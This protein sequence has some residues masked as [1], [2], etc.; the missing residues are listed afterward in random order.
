MENYLKFLHNKALKEIIRISEDSG[1][2]RLKNIYL[3]ENVNEKISNHPAL[4]TGLDSIP[5]G[6]NQIV[7][8]LV[9]PAEP[10]KSKLTL[11]DENNEIILSDLIRSYALNKIDLLVIPVVN[12]KTLEQKTFLI[13]N[14]F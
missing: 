14:K 4:F 5:I 8:I 7:R 13:E 9:E 12:S 1:F 10:S 6:T 3:T 2:I 11:I